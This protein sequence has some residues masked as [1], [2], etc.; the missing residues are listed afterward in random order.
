M[1]GT[2]ANSNELGGQPATDYVTGF[3]QISHTANTIP[4]GNI[5]T[6]TLG[7][8]CAQVSGYRAL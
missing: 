7:S 2:A 5:D 1:A 3:G 4:F 8:L 6:L